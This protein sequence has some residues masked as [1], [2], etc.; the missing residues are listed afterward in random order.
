[1][2]EGGVSGT[3]VNTPYDMPLIKQGDPVTA[4]L[5]HIITVKF[6]EDL[7]F[8][9]LTGLP[10][11]HEYWDR[12]FVDDCVL[13][14]RSQVDY[15]YREEPVM[16]REGDKD[17]DS[18][19]RLRGTE[20]AVAEDKAQGN[21]PHYIALGKVLNIDDSWLHLIDR[22][23]GTAFQWDAQAQAFIELD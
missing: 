7:P 16:T 23:T 10:P 5:T 11:Q 17:P 18:G 21:E 4:P 14:D 15:I 1:M 13:Q 8:P 19:W 2:A 6:S 22:E 3:L 12:C 9:D 20:Q